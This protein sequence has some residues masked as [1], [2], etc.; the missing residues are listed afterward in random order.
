MT[1]GMFHQGDLQS[2]IGLAIQQNKLVS[3]FVCEEDDTVSQEWETTF[4]P[5]LGSEIA[6][7]TILLKIKLNSPE[8]GFLSAFCPVQR[9]PTFIVIDNGRVVD[10]IE[11]E[12]EQKDWEAR[13]KKALDVRDGASHQQVM[14]PQADDMQDPAIA[15]TTSIDSSPRSCETMQ[16]DVSPGEPGSPRRIH[17]TLESLLPGRAAQLEADH[18]TRRAKEK[19]ERIARAEA[20]RK[21]VE[22][23]A[24]SDDKSSLSEKAKG[25]QR[26]DGSGDASSQ[27]S[28]RD[29]VKEQAKRKEEAKVERQRILQQIEADRQERKNREA[30]RKEVNAPAVSMNGLSENRSSTSNKS[31]MCALQLRLFDGTSIK[32]RFKS[33]T[34]LALGVRTWIKETAPAGAA[35]SA[36]N[37]RLMLVP[38]PSR[39][40]DKADET[41]S[42]QE[43]GLV[44]SATLVLL[45]A[46]DAAARDGFLSRGVVGS[47]Y[48]LV[49]GALGVVGGAVG[50]LTGGLYIG[51]IADETEPSN[52]AGASMA[53]TDTPGTLSAGKARSK[54]LAD[55]RA[56]ENT[57]KDQNAEFYNGNSSAFEGRKDPDVDE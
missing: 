30:I 8:A 43:L 16:P 13:V 9:A 2:G 40:I 34:T 20:R 57:A 42:L 1:S 46:I 25:K 55:Q 6:E 31:D 12:L 15:T 44:P 49:S 4:L 18:Q 50:H 53:T 5:L 10:K 7:K 47:V 33:S 19:E 29:W 36:Y 39:T 26:A 52:I 3:C 21:E 28:R 54:T 41:K 24:T 32:T 27:Q 37:F 17:P 11:G 23:A 48:G 38:G 45:P 14:L 35:D 56:E 22:A 51:G